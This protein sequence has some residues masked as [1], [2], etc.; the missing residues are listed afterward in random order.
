MALQGILGTRQVE[1]HGSADFEQD[2]FQHSMRSSAG[3]Q[4]HSWLSTEIKSPSRGVISV[5]LNLLA[6]LRLQ[7]SQLPS[8]FGK[9]P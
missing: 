4:T 5:Q 7:I 9:S 2:G 1:D 8:L 6:A 3:N